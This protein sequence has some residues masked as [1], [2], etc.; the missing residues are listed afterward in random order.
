M[1]Q[2]AGQKRLGRDQAGII[3]GGMTRGQGSGEVLD[4]G[5]NP[6]DGD[7]E[8]GKQ[9]GQWEQEQ[10]GKVISEPTCSEND[11]KMSKF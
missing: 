7:E 11:I 6:Q 8:R 4:G 1:E 10:E 9:P 5:D 3:R 2:R